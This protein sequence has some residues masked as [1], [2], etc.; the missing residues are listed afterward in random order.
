MYVY[1]FLVLT[2]SGS[3]KKLYSGNK[4]EGVDVGVGRVGVD[5]GV[6]RVGVDVGVGRVGVDVGVGEGVGD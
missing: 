5:V 1:H 2:T 4:T 6:G 3:W